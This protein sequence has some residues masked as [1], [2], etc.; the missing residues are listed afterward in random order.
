MTITADAAPLTFQRYLTETPAPTKT[1]EHILT[2]PGFGRHF[3][4]HMVAVDWSSDRGWHDARLQPYGPLEMSPASAVL[5]YG[6]EVFEGLKAYRHADGSIWTFRP[7]QNAA[8]LQRSARRL[9]LPELSTAD[10]LESLRVLVSADAAWVPSGAERS[11]YLRPFIIAN[12]TFIGVR[13]ARVAAY[14]A[15]ASPAGSSIDEGVKPV[16]IWVS[17]EFSRAGRGGT[18]AAKSGGN[19]AASL[20]PQQEAQRNGCA[21]VLFADAETGTRVDEVGSMNIFFLTREN[22][23][24]TPAASGSILE[25]ITRDSVIQLA[26]DRGLRVDER[27]VLISELCD[28]LASGEITEIFA[29]GTAGVITPIAQVKSREGTW[30]R[31]DAAVGPVTRELRDELTGIQHGHRA[32]RYGWMWRLDE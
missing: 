6:Q 13:P 9:A 20:L 30:G 14:Y 22:S 18:G 1:R 10:F 21:Q 3:T 17:T 26:R 19:Y 29:T 25:G 23:L 7:E 5:H 16:S 11:L 4:D 15:I 8:R 12:E 28:G 31:V 2:D 24:V 27:D 32:D